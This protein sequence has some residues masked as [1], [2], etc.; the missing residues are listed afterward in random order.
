[1]FNDE[2]TEDGGYLWSGRRLPD[3]TYRAA[4][5]LTFDQYNQ[6]EA[7]TL[8]YSDRNGRQEVGLTVIDEPRTSLQATIESVAVI[9]RVADSAERQ[10]RLEQY[11]QS[12]QRTGET[13]ANRL[14]AGKDASK[15]AL[16]WL[17]D[18]KG[19]PR[20]RLSVDSLGTAKVE[21]MDESGK[22]TDS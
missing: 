1:Y 22:V 5:F 14:F 9:R 17:A 8:G 20:L 2:G 15:S 12:L 10:R 6:D 4:G 13:R 3:G 18:Q 19:R 7:L 16:V 21:L 11:F